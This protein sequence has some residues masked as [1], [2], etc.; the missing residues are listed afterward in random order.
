MD[1]ILEDLSDAMNTTV[2]FWY[3][4]ENVTPVTL[5]FEFA[6]GPTYYTRYHVETYDGGSQAVADYL[7]QAGYYDDSWIWNYLNNDWG[8]FNGTWRDNITWSFSNYHREYGYAPQQGYFELISGVIL[9]IDPVFNDTWYDL[10][11]FFSNW[12]ASALGVNDTFSI[13]VSGGSNGTHHTILD[14][15][16]ALVAPDDTS[17]DPDGNLFIAHWDNVTL[18]NLTGLLFRPWDGGLSGGY[19]D[20][21]VI[22]PSNPF[23]MYDPFL[24]VRLEI[25]N[26]S[27][28]TAVTMGVATDPSAPGGGLTP[29]GFYVNISTAVNLT[30]VEGWITFYYTDA[31]VQALGLN[32]ETLEVYWYNPATSSYEALSPVIRNTDE[33]W[34]SGYLDH[35]SV[36]VLLALPAGLPLILILAIVAVV[37]V[38]AG[39]V[40]Y[41]LLRRRAVPTEG[42]VKTDSEGWTET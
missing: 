38:A 39:G 28:A 26:A 4:N 30:T 32:E 24:G 5:H 6:Y 33:N 12:I 40:G 25:T 2:D 7:Y 1:T 35:L 41:V 18:D 23:L 31:M 9:D 29:V 20:P 14:A 17:N 16:S 34:V 27:E 19:I 21:G 15:G 22:G 11:D 10:D 42:K 13:T 37:V 8:Y 3:W 36:F